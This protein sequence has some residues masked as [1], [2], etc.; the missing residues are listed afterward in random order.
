M[1]H[2]HP[3]ST[4]TDPALVRRWDRAADALWRRLCEGVSAPWLDE[5]RQLR[6]E[7]DGYSA[8]LDI[9]TVAITA[10]LKN[11]ARRDEASVVLSRLRQL[12]DVIEHGD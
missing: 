10:E 12:P 7:R 6:T 2:P 3:K 5:V 1:T 9:W 8:S 4:M 11:P